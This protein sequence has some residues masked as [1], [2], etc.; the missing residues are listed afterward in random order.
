MKRLVAAILV[1]LAVS[2]LGCG[3]SVDVK[4]GAAEPIRVENG[5]F[6]AGPLPTGSAGP[7]I[8]AID[9]RNSII[10]QAQTGKKLTGNAAKG[11]MAVAV[12]FDDIGNGYWLVPVGP[13]DPQTEGELTWTV[14]ADFARDAQPG[15]HNLVFSASNAHGDFG[16]SKATSVVVRSLTPDGHVV[17]SLSWDSD[18]DL[19]LHLVSPDGTELDPKHPNTLA[20]DDAGAPQPGN[21]VLDR[22]SNADCRSDGYRQEDVAWQDAPRSGNYI[23]RVDMF[24]ACGAPSADFTFAIRVDGKLIFT[25]SGRLL[26]MDASGG[27]PGAGLFVTEF[28]F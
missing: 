26:A 24:D 9:S 15:D 16:P 8:T 10:P 1:P 6:F 22:D 7:A 18:A 28:H 20:L 14:L 3:P 17:V 19:D 27:G 21:G 5:Q 13:P 2:A 25:R 23:A 11:A 12:R 4:S